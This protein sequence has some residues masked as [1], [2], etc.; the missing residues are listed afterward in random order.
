MMEVLRQEVLS[1]KK[2]GVSFTTILPAKVDTGLFEGA[3]GRLD[4]IEELITVV[5]SRLYVYCV[6][7]LNG[8][9]FPG[10]V[11]FLRQ[12]SLNTLQIE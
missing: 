9:I 1:Q 12:F 5:L 10:S 6:I 8:V 2:H 11:H 7:S 4:E 3:K